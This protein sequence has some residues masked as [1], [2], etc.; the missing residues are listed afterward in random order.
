M[1]PET[2]GRSLEQ[3]DG[4]FEH[5]N[6][7][8]VFKSSHRIRDQG[9]DDWRWTKKMKVEDHAEL[10]KGKKRGTAIRSPEEDERDA[11]QSWKKR[12]IYTFRRKASNA[13]LM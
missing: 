9:I 11:Q 4:F 5:G 8:N 12:P 13:G 3:M 1:Y 7:W 10:G 6:S 2:A